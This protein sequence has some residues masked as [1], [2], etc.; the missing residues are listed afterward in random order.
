LVQNEGVC[1]LLRHT[2]LPEV[3]IAEME[4]VNF[5]KSFLSHQINKRVD[6]LHGGM[7]VGN[8]LVDQRV[9]LDQFFAVDQ[10]EIV[11]VMDETLSREP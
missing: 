8:Q 6:F 4:I 5:A 7:T 2:L 9:L 11:E 1:L 10:G 3:H